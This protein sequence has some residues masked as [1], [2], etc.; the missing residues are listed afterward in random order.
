V[1][2]ASPADTCHVGDSAERIGYDTLARAN[3]G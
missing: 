3:V 2:T 1:A